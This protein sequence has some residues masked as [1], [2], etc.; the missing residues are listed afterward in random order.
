MSARAGIR[1]VARDTV[2]C[3]YDDLK[4]LYTISHARAIPVEGRKRC[5]PDHRQLLENASNIIVM[6]S[7][8]NR[9]FSSFLASFLPSIKKVSCGTGRWACMDEQVGS[10]TRL[11]KP[12]RADGPIERLIESVM[13]KGEDSGDGFSPFW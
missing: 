5:R 13:A 6:L 1:G 11:I 9:N 8:I 4:R 2:R 7:S 3:M 10:L 12:E